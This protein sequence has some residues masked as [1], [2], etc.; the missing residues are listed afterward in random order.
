MADLFCDDRGILH[1][2]L[3][4]LQLIVEHHARN[5]GLNLLLPVPH[6]RNHSVHRHGRI[7]PSSPSSG[8]WR[9]CPSSPSLDSRLKFSCRQGN[10]DVDSRS[11]EADIRIPL[12]FRTWRRRSKT[13]PFVFPLPDSSTSTDLFSSRLIFCLHFYTITLDF[14]A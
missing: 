5:H 3:R 8:E 4:V 10:W 6:G 1:E 12:G 14:D 7:L 2:F 13:F 11:C 9:L